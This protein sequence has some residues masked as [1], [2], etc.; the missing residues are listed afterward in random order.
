M[1]TGR[2]WSL[3]AAAALMLA[4]APAAGAVVSKSVIHVR[5]PATV[6]AGKPFHASGDAEFDLRLHKPPY[7]YLHAGLFR[8][9]T[10]KPCWHTF[11][12][13]T[14]GKPGSSQCSSHVTM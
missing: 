12:R 10:T 9:R 2:Q 14:R 5:A 3:V 4:A 7:D 13:T 8:R 11:C 1:R 6:K